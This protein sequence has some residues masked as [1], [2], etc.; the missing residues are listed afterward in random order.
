MRVAVEGG[1]CSGFKYDVSSEL[2]PV[3]TFNFLINSGPNFFNKSLCG[4]LCK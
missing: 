1:G 4:M 3:I 2:T